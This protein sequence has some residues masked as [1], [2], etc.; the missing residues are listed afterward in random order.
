MDDVRVLLAVRHPLIRDAMHSILELN[1]FVVAG[2]VSLA[3]DV[4]KQAASLQPHV[5]LLDA[6]LAGK[7]G[8]LVTRISSASPKTKVVI[9]ADAD[10]DAEYA[11]ARAKGVAGMI[12]K[13]APADAL[14]SSLLAIVSGKAK[15]QAGKA[16]TGRTPSGRTAVVSRPLAVTK[17]ASAASMVSMASIASMGTV[18]RLAHTYLG[19]LASLAALVVALAALI[20]L[21][22]TYL[23]TYP[24]PG[25]DF[26]HG[27]YNLGFL[28][29][30]LG[31]WFAQWNYAWLNG[32]PFS[33]EYG[34]LSSYMGL[35]FAMLLGDG[36]GLQ[37]LLIATRF[38]FALFA[39][40]LMRDLS[41]R[42]VVAMSLTILVMW[43]ANIYHDF[44]E[45]GTTAAA[46]AQMFFPLCLYLLMKSL[47]AGNRR[48]FVLA[49]LLNGLAFLTHPIGGAL[50]AAF[51]ALIVLCTGSKT[52]RHVY[53]ETLWRAVSY[54]L[55][56]A[57]IGAVVGA[58]L[59]LPAFLGMNGSVSQGTTAVNIRPQAPIDMFLTTNPVL[60]AVLVLV[61]A[62]GLYQSRKR[63]WRHG[64]I[65][66][67]ASLAAAVVVL[68]IVQVAFAR[69]I[70]PAAVSLFA[71]RTWFLAPVLL[72]GIAATI[73]GGIGAAT[74][75][76]DAKI[77][78]GRRVVILPASVA[79][80]AAFLVAAA[81]GPLAGAP[82]IES[83]QRL[84][85]IYPPEALQSM[86]YPGDP[87]GQMVLPDWL[88]ADETNLRAWVPTVLTGGWWGVLH[89]MPMTWGYFDP[90]HARLK[91]WQAW[92][93]SSMRGDPSKDPRYAPEVAKNEAKFLIDW[94]ALRYFIAEVGPAEAPPLAP[95]LQTQDITEE[96][97][98]AYDLRISRARADIAG[99]IVSATNAPTV[100]VIGDDNA[101]DA[102]MRSIALANLGPRRVILIRGPKNI[103]DVGPDEL[104]HFRGVILYNYGYADFGRAFGML[105]NYVRRGGGLFVDSGSFVRESDLANL[106]GVFPIG[107]ASRGPL[108]G[109]WVLDRSE[110]PLLAGVDTTGFS[111][112][113]YGGGPWAL[114]YSPEVQ[115]VRPWA[116][117]VLG[118]SGR[119]IMAAGMLDNGRVVWR[120]VNLPY[121]VI[122]YINSQEASLLANVIRWIAPEQAEGAAGY[123]VSRP[124]PGTV[125]VTGSG[126]RGVL[127]KESALDGWVARTVKDRGSASLKIY[128]AGPDFMYVPV[129]TSEQSGQATVQLDF[130]GS[131]SDWVLFGIALG[132]ILLSLDYVLFGGGIALARMARASRPMER[133]AR[134]LWLQL[135]SRLI[136]EE[137]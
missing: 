132:T 72:A 57:L 117:M 61:I 79:L 73:V 118:Q 87:T 107:E 20:P 63:G 26:A 43:S 24:P 34:V 23:N 48:L 98:V 52:G 33:R 81:I 124:S 74:S 90:Q 11:I 39:F 60:L 112:L 94:F 102:L 9:L 22:S 127:F 40:L 12:Y 29:R 88:D 59:L 16:Q 3:S 116:R 129:P 125:T 120:G 4:V 35:P 83:I 62:W 8:M 1:R 128:A 67:L 56:V 92:L 122:S 50:I 93:T 46:T 84:P 14:V 115:D 66:Q 80:S 41:G 76:G 75:A 64:A 27:V 137:E 19:P 100:L 28:H 10:E 6:Q 44:V 65:R 96:S 111:P 135:S 136:G 45:G 53:L 38:V 86:M 49:A 104:N 121:H 119:P 36:P 108:E 42:S 126:F 2:S 15:I 21:T 13:D 47:R 113:R 68:E 106:P 97:A 105:E 133:P 82:R 109:Q 78:R 25:V 70:N 114:S 37:A 69:G 85:L 51:A 91:D 134:R 55:I 131:P 32:L 101:Y 5:V 17:D 7:G 71:D 130:R 110:S 103:D 95:Y 54:S 18:S 99:P 89:R 58:P 31:V 30:N 123:A 77:T